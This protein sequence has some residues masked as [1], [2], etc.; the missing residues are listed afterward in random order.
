MVENARWDSSLSFILAMIGASVM[1]F[2]P[3]A[4]EAFLSLT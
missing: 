4:E 2:I 1:C 3:M